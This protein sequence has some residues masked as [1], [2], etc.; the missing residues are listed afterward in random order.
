[1]RRG[2]EAA[3]SFPIVVSALPGEEFS[4]AD[5]S[6]FVAAPGILTGMKTTIPFRL[7]YLLSL[8]A[9]A[10]AAGPPAPPAAPLREQPAQNLCLETE[11]K[12]RRVVVAAKVCFREGT[13]E[14]LL[15]R[16]H[17]KEHEYVLAADVD[18]RQVHT[19]LLAAGARAGKPV[20][21][22][23]KYVPATG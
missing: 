15:C 23:P 7:A 4:P 13:L 10:L 2:A 5:H 20:Q 21:F 12:Q 11:G 8:T 9:A 16:T 14:G 1:A 18:G 17:T 19:A 3:R 22:V 6:T